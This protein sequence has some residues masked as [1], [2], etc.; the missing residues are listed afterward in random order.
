LLDRVQSVALRLCD[1]PLLG[2]ARPELS[3]S[4]RSLV[5]DTP[6]IL[7]YIADGQ[8]NYG[9]SCVASCKGCA[10][11]G[12]LSSTRKP[13]AVVGVGCNNL[14]LVLFIGFKLACFTNVI[15]VVCFCAIVV[16]L[17]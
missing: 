17:I 12:F 7:F 3:D 14:Y 1:H 6:Y 8:K 16:E 5:T 4:V 2:K 15:V 10:G 11:N 13:H 9:Y